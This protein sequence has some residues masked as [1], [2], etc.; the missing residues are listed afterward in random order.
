MRLL[1]EGV[2]NTYPLI[3]PQKST[4]KGQE[5]KNIINSCFLFSCLAVIV[6]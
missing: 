5:K 2:K 4:C 1:P 6:K 3:C